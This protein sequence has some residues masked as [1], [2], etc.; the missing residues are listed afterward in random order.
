MIHSPLPPIENVGK[1]IS[2]RAEENKFL[3]RGKYFFVATPC[4]R[5]L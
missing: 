2:E 3:S 5:S 1:K 4:F